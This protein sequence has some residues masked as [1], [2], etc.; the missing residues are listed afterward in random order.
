MAGFSCAVPLESERLFLGSCTGDNVL[1]GYTSGAG[2]ND[3]GGVSVGMNDVVDDLD[4][5][6]GDDEEEGTVGISGSQGKLR[7][8]VHD[9]L[10]STAPIRDAAFA[11]PAFTDVL[12]LSRLFI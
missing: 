12:S 8:H 6:Y 9:Y 7:L 2:A 3:S 10:L 1:L 5:I 4:A 11:N